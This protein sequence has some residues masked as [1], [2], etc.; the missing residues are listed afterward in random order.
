MQAGQIISVMLQ[1]KGLSKTE[2]SR[3]IGKSADYFSAYISRHSVPK[4]NTMAEWCELL[5]WELVIRDLDDG[6][7]VK[8]DPPA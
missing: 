7:E 2:A 3:L 4:L 5:G 8:I 1:K 6:F